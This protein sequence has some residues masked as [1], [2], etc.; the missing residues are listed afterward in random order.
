MIKGVEAAPAAAAP[1]GGSNPLAVDIGVP[2][3][4]LRERWTD[5]L[6]REYLQALIAKVGRNAGSL[7]DAAGLD[8]SY[9][10]RLLKKHAL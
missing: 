9:I 2:F 8:R 5:H 10:N 3:K 6:K 1:A 7:A 4:D